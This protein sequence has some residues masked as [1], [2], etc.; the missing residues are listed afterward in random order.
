MSQRRV[1]QAFA[2]R[3]LGFALELIEHGVEAPPGYEHSCD[4][5]LS[6]HFTS[7]T[8]APTSTVVHCG[9]KRHQDERE[10]FGAGRSLPNGDLVL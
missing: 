1:S 7:V 4:P 8:N 9:G 2:R 3:H 6:D 10:A 5:D